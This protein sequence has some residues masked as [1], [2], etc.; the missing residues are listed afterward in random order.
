ML[1]ERLYPL[2]AQSEPA[3]AG[4]I[5]GMLLE[6][7][8]REVL[9]LLESEQSLQMKIEEA[10]GVLRDAGMISPSPAG[11]SGR[12]NTRPSP[13]TIYRRTSDEEQDEE[14]TRS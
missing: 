11:R 13:R 7:D 6:M 4:K 14:L 9:H 8:N 1:G 12:V 2:I 5:T 3:R 10:L